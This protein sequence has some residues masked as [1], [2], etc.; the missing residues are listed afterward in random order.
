MKTKEFI[1]RAKE[2]GFVAGRHLDGNMAIFARDGIIVL[3]DEYMPYGLIMDTKHLKY[4]T[5]ELFDLCV[6]YARTPIDKRED[7]ERFYL[8]KI[9]DFYDVNYDEE[10]A[11]LNF[12]V[13][14]NTFYLS[15]KSHSTELK[16]QFTQN[17]IDKIKGEQHTD[18]SEFIQIPVEEVDY[19]N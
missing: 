16:T 15:N 4:L 2:L 11:Y 9:E 1:R 17:E 13:K 6:E 8:Q 14:E 3:I 18:L 5:K 19:D 10:F 12:D 7:K